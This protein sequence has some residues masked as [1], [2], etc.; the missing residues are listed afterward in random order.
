MVKGKVSE[1]I[2]SDLQSVCV[3]AVFELNQWRRLYGGRFDQRIERSTPK[4]FN[5]DIERMFS[6]LLRKKKKKYSPSHIA[7]VKAHSPSHLLFFFFPVVPCT[8]M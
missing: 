8:G 3:R 1:T 5:I 2:T 7:S 4:C 6:S